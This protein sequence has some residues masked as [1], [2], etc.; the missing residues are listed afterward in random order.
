M[1]A[2]RS[3]YGVDIKKGDKVVFGN[4]DIMVDIGL[5][6]LFKKNVLLE[7]ASLSDV[8]LDIEQSP[9]GDLRIASYSS[10]ASTTDTKTEELPSE[11]SA[12]TF[13]AKMI[14]LDT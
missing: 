9:K 12:W 4:S 2:I 3:Y 7:R 10:K 1:Y 5:K 11:P 14:N 8:V 13:T 6:N